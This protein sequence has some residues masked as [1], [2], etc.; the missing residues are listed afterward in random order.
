MS[1]ATLFI[2]AGCGFTTEENQR[3][4]VTGGQ[5]FLDQLWNLYSDWVWK[6]RRS[7]IDSLR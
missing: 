2:C 3:E 4:G 1:K 6:P 5:Y 7:R